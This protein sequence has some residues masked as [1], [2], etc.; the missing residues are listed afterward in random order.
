M[1]YCVGFRT[2]THETLDPHN[3]WIW[4]PCIF[5]QCVSILS[6]MQKWKMYQFAKFIVWN[7]TRA[8]CFTLPFFTVCNLNIK[9]VFERG[10]SHLSWD[11]GI[12][13]QK[14]LEGYW[15]DVNPLM[16]SLT[17]SRCCGGANNLLY[18]RPNSTISWHLW[19]VPNVGLV[20]LKKFKFSLDKCRV[21][22]EYWHSIA[23][24]ES[25]ISA[26]THIELL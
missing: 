7:E 10:L 24:I 6:I 22:W 16:K 11:M 4:N 3:F 17:I 5:F 23:D 19:G 26:Q 25:Q 13:S 1:L 9:D 15:G 20:F 14:Y 21:R 2:H 18:H 12:V 8:R